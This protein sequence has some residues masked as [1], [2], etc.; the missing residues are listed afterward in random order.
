MT[1]KSPALMTAPSD[2]SPEEAVRA[3][4]QALFAGGAAGLST[5]LNRTLNV[6]LDPKLLEG[7]A[8][9]RERLPL[10]WVVAEVRFTRGFRGAHTII[11]SRADA[12]AL[13][14]L[15]LGEEPSE[16]I[17]LS[18]D[19]EAA[20]R[21]LI[22]QMMS[23]AGASL[24]G[25]LGHPVAFTATDLK[26]IE[27]GASWTPPA[28]WA[29]LARVS[30]DGARQATLA[31]TVPDAVIEEPW[32]R[33]EPGQ[34]PEAEGAPAGTPTAG[35]DLILDITLP[36]T[37]ELGRAKMLIRDILGLSRGSVIELDRLA[38]EPVEIL[39]NDRPIASG[40]V[41]IID[42]NFGVRLTHISR[43]ADRIR[44]LR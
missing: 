44:S 6:D 41:V 3:Y 5:L 2:H 4:C 16:S 29:A 40:E 7:T 21:E 26:F 34:E 11:L 33:A 8:A 19:H 15:A 39:V 22:N 23:S 17:A 24:R 1:T 18:A 43:P 36:I 42:E 10:P 12:A 14:Q 28:R 38:G 13:A 37:V 27:P 20:L 35:L 32:A 31:L 30:V 9:L 25:L